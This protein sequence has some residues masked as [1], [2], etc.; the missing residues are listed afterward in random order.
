MVFF[1][2]KGMSVA[3]SVEHLTLAQV[4]ISWFM[5]SSP[6]SGSALVARSLEPALNSVS[7]S[8]SLPLRHSHS[9]FVSQKA[10][11]C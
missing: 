11:K 2:L 3:Q 5:G 9:L 6:E 7:P 4:M 1:F 8:L 10:N